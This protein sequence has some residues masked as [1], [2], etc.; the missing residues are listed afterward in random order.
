MTTDNGI[1]GPDNVAFLDEYAGLALPALASV[2]LLSMEDTQLHGAAVFAL[3]GPGLPSL[4]ARP[5]PGSF[6]EVDFRADGWTV[7]PAHEP[8]GVE[9]KTGSIENLQP[10]TSYM[11]TEVTAPDGYA[12]AAAQQFVTSHDGQI[13]I[14]QFFNGPISASQSLG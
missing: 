1:D 10:D 3:S 5:I 11:M 4:A 12:V 14:V 7:C 9:C 2:N 6:A 8:P 13:A